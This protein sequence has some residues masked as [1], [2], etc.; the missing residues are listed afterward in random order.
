MIMLSRGR[1]QVKLTKLKR[2][3]SILTHKDAAADPNITLSNK[4]FSKIRWASKN[5]SLPVAG[6]VATNSSSSMRIAEESLLANKLSTTDITATNNSH[7]IKRITKSDISAEANRCLT[8]ANTPKDL[9]VITMTSST[10]ITISKA[11]GTIKGTTI[12][13]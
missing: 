3:V 9:M 13:I 7:T 1:N 10:I 8:V 6:K 11:I 12:I 4:T 2:A 5:L